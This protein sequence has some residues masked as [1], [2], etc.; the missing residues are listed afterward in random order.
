[1]REKFSCNEVVF[2][3]EKLR[4]KIKLFIYYPFIILHTSRTN[5][6]FKYYIIHNNYTIFRCV[7]ICVCE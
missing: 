2:H 5:K 4:K 6:E 7:S 3:N 1:M